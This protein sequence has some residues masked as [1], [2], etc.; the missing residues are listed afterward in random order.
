MKKLP[1]AYNPSKV[2]YIL[3][4]LAS[5][6]V[7]IAGIKAAEAIIVPFLTAIFFTLIIFPIIFWSQK[8]A[9]PIGISIL[10]TSL[11]IVSLFTFFIIILG[12]NIQALAENIPDY[13]ELLEERWQSTTV[14]WHA[15]GVDMSILKISDLIVVF[16][17]LRECAAR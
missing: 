5:F 4:G 7:I 13:H 2:V 16:R 11:I 3:I 14:F 6:V 15:R 12:S 9:V 8:K 17:Y 1:E 10:L